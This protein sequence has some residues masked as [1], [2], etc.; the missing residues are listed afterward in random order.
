M[1][2]LLLYI[3]FIYLLAGISASIIYHRILTHKAIAL[4]PWF[5]KMMVVLALPAGT[6]IQWVGTHRQHHLY[7]DVEGDPH[8]PHVNGFWYAHC[9]WYLGSRNVFI[10]FPYSIGGPLRMLF[11]GYWRPRNRLE[12]NHLAQDI[13][14]QPFYKWISQ[15]LHY[16]LCLW[17]YL[18]LLLVPVFLLWEMTGI[19]A[20]WA[21]LVL[22]YNLGDS[23]NSLG[24]LYGERV[25]NK[26]K[27]RNNALLAFFTFGEGFHANHHRSPHQLFSQEPP[28]FHLSNAVIQVW[29][30]LGLVK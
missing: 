18:L 13:E 11:D 19:L 28:G 6:P 21:I 30:I 2:G 22:V 29:K 12:Y 27:A 14:E 7:T 16:M 4:Q 3:A 26:N 24:H 17:L 23:V 9:G 15:P 10:C 1:L 25:G 8:S 5:E 20:L